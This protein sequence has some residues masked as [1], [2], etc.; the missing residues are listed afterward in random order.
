MALRYRIDVMAALKARGY[1]SSRI[2]GEKL[3]GQSY[4]QQIRHGELVSWKTIDTLCMLLDCQPGD[5]VEYVPDDAGTP[6]PPS[7]FED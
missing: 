2:R 7:A 1:T 5:I 3:I 6:S 4:L